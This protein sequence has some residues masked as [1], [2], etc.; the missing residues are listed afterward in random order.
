MGI[1]DAEGWF[2]GN[3]A[4]ESFTYG[5]YGAVNREFYQQVPEAVGQG[6]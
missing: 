2:V 3:E 5:T 6:I 4:S 1:R